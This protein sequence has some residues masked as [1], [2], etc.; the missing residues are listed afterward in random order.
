MA[1]NQD[2]DDGNGPRGLVGRAPPGRLQRLRSLLPAR[3]RD[4]LVP[5][6]LPALGGVLNKLEAGR[7]IAD[8]GRGRG[9]SAVL[10]AQAYPNALITDHATTEIPRRSHARTSA[11][12]R[13]ICGVPF[14]SEA[15]PCIEVIPGVAPTRRKALCLPPANGPS[16][17]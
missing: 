9:T 7:L 16:I 10:L 5:S 15:E 13:W 2:Q 4:Q 1:L 6:W 12:S 11:F 17:P 14:L 8:V 3:L